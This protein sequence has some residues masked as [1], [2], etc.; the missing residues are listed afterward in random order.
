MLLPDSDTDFRLLDGG[1]TIPPELK[2]A[3][4]VIGNFDGVH[5]GHRV[6][7]Q[8]AMD[9]A[10]GAV[11][12]LAL[13]FEP[14]P[15]TVFNP[16]DPVFRLS[17]KLEKASLLRACGLRGVLNWD[18]SR[19][20]AGLSAQTF[21][22]DILVGH[23]AASHVVV[24]YD[25][26]FGKSREG[27]PA[28]LFAAGQSAGFGV[29][30]VPQVNL[31]DGLAVSSSAIRT[32]LMNADIRSANNELGYHWFVQADVIHGEKRGRELGYPTANMKLSPHCRL[33]L[34]IY[35]VSV[36]RHNGT[37]HHSVASY[38]RRPQFDN[39]A[40]LLETHLF[41]F[42]DDLYGETLMVTFHEFLRGEAR[43]D[44]VD[45]LV[46]QMDR[47]SAAARRI[48]QAALPLS[49]LDARLS[50]QP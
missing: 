15:R 5:A 12:V 39:G 35:A 41:D 48:L 22:E 30:V 1:T 8:H 25:F 33:A 34:G 44:G 49:P 42:S 38:G 21:V 31:P 50:F 45:A 9:L 40:A 46:A 2:G 47:D 6:I 36:R 7:L 17:P 10:A 27:S 13:T 26:H 43:F 29:T 11:P 28:F 20:F 23:L 4:V 24:G 19:E 16:S 37:L 32:H 3:I 14:H 18:F